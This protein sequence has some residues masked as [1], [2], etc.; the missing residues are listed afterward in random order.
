MA[1]TCIAA[2]EVDSLLHAGEIHVWT[3]TVSDWLPHRAALGAT[4]DLAEREKAAR[5][6]FEKDRRRFTLC[7][8][9]LRAQLGDYLSATPHG[10]EFHFG[11]QDKPALPP[12]V[13][14]RIE[15]NLSHS[16]EAAYFAF[17]AGKR[18]GVDIEHMRPRTDV[19]GLGRQVFTPEERQ[20][21]SAAPEQEKQN[22]FFSM[23]TQKEAYIKA[24]GLGLAAPVREITVG[25]GLIPRGEETWIGLVQG[26]GAIWSVLKLP[27]PDG[28]KAALAVEGRISSDRLR[29]RPL[30]P[31]AS[32]PD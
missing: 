32:L 29:V 13:S 7:R 20:K 16:D 27:A 3:V 4:L 30:L 24:I 31:P 11:D 17:A 18:V 6:R 25:E 26:Y 12:G 22:V 14:S 23:W 1:L 8:G 21:L 19:D 10:I 15:F 28:Y 9:L 5:F 2:S